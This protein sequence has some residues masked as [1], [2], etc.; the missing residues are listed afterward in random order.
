MMWQIVFKELFHILACGLWVHFYVSASTLGGD[1]PDESL[2]MSSNRIEVT[3]HG[4]ALWS[5][6]LQLLLPQMDRGLIKVHDVQ[7]LTKPVNV[8]GHK[9]LLLR[10]LLSPGS[11]EGEMVLGGEKANAEPLVMV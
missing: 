1:S 6:D 11:F 5:P 2:A 7:L 3:I 8:L 4:V 9:L 10:Q